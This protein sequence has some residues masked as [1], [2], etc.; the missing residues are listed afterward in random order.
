MKRTDVPQDGGLFD[1]MFEVQYAVDENGRYVLEESA[2]W[3]AKAI[4]N[5]QFWQTVEEDIRQSIEEVRMGRSSPLRVYMAL[6]QMDVGLL[7]SH[8]RF[9]R[10]QVRRHLKPH[11]FARLK[12][13]L[14]RRYAQVF[15]VPLD[16][17]VRVP[18]NLE[19]WDFIHRLAH[20]YD[21]GDSAHAP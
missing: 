5:S 9:W 2:G 10:W 15:N 17:L 4:A 18:E 16:L 14:L 6:H 19:K 20:R 8:A 21:P 1:G 12:P 7:A 13:D 3:E 11:V